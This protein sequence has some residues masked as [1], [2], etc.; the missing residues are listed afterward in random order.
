MIDGG[1][2]EGAGRGVE[3]VAQADAPQLTPQ[4][5]D[6][7]LALAGR[8]P[9]GGRRLGLTENRPVLLFGSGLHRGHLGIVV[10]PQV[11]SRVP[12][13]GGPVVF[14]DVGRKPLQVLEVPGG[15]GE[16]HEPVAQLE[17]AESPDGAP[18]RKPRRGRFA[19]QAVD[20]EDPVP[21]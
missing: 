16:G 8:H 12:D 4:P 1:P 5:T 11:S 9:T 15:V 7:A 18:Q 13:R 10:P 14:D 20:E 17:G 2:R 21:A 3:V 19:G 6:D